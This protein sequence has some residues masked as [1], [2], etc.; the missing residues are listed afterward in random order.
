M[1]VM[2]G[3][4]FGAI[5]IPVST[6]SEIGGMVLFIVVVALLVGLAV[7]RVL[8]RPTERPMFWG[9]LG[10]AGGI[11]IVLLLVG[12][13]AGGIMGPLLFVPVVTG[14]LVAL[15]VARRRG[16]ARR[17]KAFLTGYATGLAL[18]GAVMMPLLGG[19]VYGVTTF[20]FIASSVLL[21]PALLTIMTLEAVWSWDDAFPTIVCHRRPI[22][23]NTQGSIDRDAPESNN[24]DVEFLE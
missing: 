11:G 20:S 9:S 16:G 1:I 23:A 21:W 4:A 12:T 19:L 8:R 5:I 3:F 7:V 15:W 18:L 13:I 10:A 22:S 24:H 14:G 17:A 6:Y 2:G